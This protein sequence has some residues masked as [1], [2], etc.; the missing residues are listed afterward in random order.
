MIFPHRGIKVVDEYWDYLIILD[1]CRYDFFE[2]MNIIPGRLEKKKSLASATV[3]WLEK[4][5]DKYYG[6][7]IYIS[8]NPLISNIKI[9]GF[10]GTD[11]FFKVENVWDYGW[12]KDLGTVPP[13][14]VTSAALRMKAKYPNKRMIIHYMQPHGPWIGKTKLSG[15]ELNLTFSTA[16]ELVYNPQKWRDVWDKVSTKTIKEAYK[17]NLKLVLN[18]V[19]KL[20]NKLDGKIV[21]SSDH[22]ECLGEKLLFEHQIGIYVRELID[23]PW[24]IIEKPKKAKSVEI[25]KARIKNVIKELKHNGKI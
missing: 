25:E 15:K 2:K 22:G 20:V 19:K 23:V 4:N 17:D 24:Q 12:D 7:I 14:E 18:E 6:D 21:I 9:Y 11:H 1:A 8:S 13:E 3:E 10:K 5:F 16:V